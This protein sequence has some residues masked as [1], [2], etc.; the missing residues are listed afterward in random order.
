M[1]I[2]K[3]VDIIENE[4]KV[5]LSNEENEMYEKIKDERSIDKSALDAREY[6]IISRLVELNIVK[7]KM[8]DGKITFSAR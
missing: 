5:M 1:N 6:R 2:V 7:R 4:L 8:H 3:I